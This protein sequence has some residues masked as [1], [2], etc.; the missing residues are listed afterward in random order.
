MLLALEIGNSHVSVGGFDGDELKFVAPI[1]TDDRLTGPQ[2]AVTLASLFTLYGAE[3]RQ[4]QHAVVGSVVPSVTPAI[5]DALAL[6]CGCEALN[7]SSG[8]KTGL[9]IKVEQPR[10]LGSDLVANAA[11][12][13]QHA[14]LPCVVVDLGTATTFTALD[15]SG[16]LI[17]T[18]IAAGVQISLEAL[19]ARTAQLTNVLSEA[20]RHGVLGRNTAEAIKAGA[21][22]GAA[23]MVDGM[24]ARYGD[25]LGQR[26]HAL[27]TGG[28]AELVQ[29]F[30]HTPVQAVPH[31][32]L[33]GL[34]L[35]WQ[36]NR[37]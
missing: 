30:L 1:A 2:I 37:S 29:P 36:R 20:P 16:A 24:L 14:P 19:R 9:N 32:T 5:M 21:V 11:W 13:C 7:V 17:G 23:A 22:Y 3:A 4:F 31:L 8:V 33:R 34:Q 18:A 27:L 35:I 25:A 10:L 15:S 26:P 6:L 28:A 12:A